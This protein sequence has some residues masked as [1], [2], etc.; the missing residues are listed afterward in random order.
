MVHR[1]LD[2]PDI[3][4]MMA[5]KPLLVQQCIHDGLYP[6]SGMQE[7]VNRIAAVYEKVGAGSQFAGRFYDTRHRFTR[8]MQSDAF[9]FFDQQFK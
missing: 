9:V 5:P 6:L 2:L 8:E 1:Y 3:V 4:S 7:S